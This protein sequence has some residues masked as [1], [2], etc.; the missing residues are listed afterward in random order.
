MDKISK[1]ALRFLADALKYE[2]RITAD[3]KIIAAEIYAEMVGL[4]NKF[5]TKKS[6]IR[7]LFDKSYGDPQKLQRATDRINDVLRYTFVLPIETYADGVRRTIEILR[8]SGYRVPE[9]KIW[10]AWE[11]IGTDKDRGYRG[12]NITV[13]SSENQKFELQFHTRESFMLK[14]ETHDLYEEAR[15]AKTSPERRKEIKDSVL[16]KAADVGIPKG[17]KEWNM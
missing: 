12:I 5:K 15:L 10:N 3:L 4:E 11:N 17:V 16:G 8:E 7:K 2:P 13:I 14:T 6:L 1:T 9:N